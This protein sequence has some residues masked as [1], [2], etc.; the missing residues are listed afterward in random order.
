[1][2]KKY[3]APVLLGIERSSDGCFAVWCPACGDFHR[4]GKELGHVRAHC[5]DEASP[6]HKTGYY[7][8]QAKYYGKKVILENK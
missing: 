3:D 2:A 4:H 6:Y 1:M 7:I 5:I 8:K